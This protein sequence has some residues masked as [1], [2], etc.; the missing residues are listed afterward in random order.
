[1]APRICAGMYT[2]IRSACPVMRTEATV[3]A[4]FKWASVSPIEIATATPENTARPQPAVMAT[5]PAFSAFDFPRRT[6]P[7]TP[8]P[9]R[10]KTAVPTN[11]PTTASLSVIDLGSPDVLRCQL[12]VPGKLVFL[13][14]FIFT[15]FFGQQL[16]YD[17]R[18][19]DACLRMEK[20]RPR[21]TSQN[22]FYGTSHLL[23]RGPEHLNPAERKVAV[24]PVQQVF[25]TCCKC[26]YFGEIGSIHP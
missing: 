17:R 6:P 24:H 16:G 2:T 11:S 26:M 7:T 25:F 14:P 21:S 12:T 23:A 9:K 20:K 3:N 18:R 10:I 1:M 4:G 8:F 5:H 13:P 15:Q 22:I 19:L